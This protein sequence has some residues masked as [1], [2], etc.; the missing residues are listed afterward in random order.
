VTSA[1]GLITYST[2]PR[3]GVVHTLALAE[4]L[5]QQG[6]PVEVVALGDPA[7]GFFRRVDAP[8]HLIPAPPVRD[9]LEER[10]AAAVDALADG[11]REQRDGGTL[12]SIL[13]VQDCISARA[14]VRLRDEGTPVTVVRTVH[15][16]DD[17]TTPELVECQ[18]RSI[19]DPDRLVV[20]SR[21]WQ[22]RLAADYGVQATVVTNGVDRKRFSRVPSPGELATR[23]AQVGAENRF[24]V[25]TVGGIEPRK[26]S[27]HLVR[28][29]AVLRERLQPPAVLAVI[30]GYSFQDHRTYR[31]AVLS[32]LPDLGLEIGRDVVLLGTLPDD[33]MPGWYHA[34][35]AFAFPS[36]NEGFGLVVLEALAAGTPTVVADL[37]A[38]REYLDY[39]RDALVVAPGDDQALADQ[40]YRIATE[41]QLRAALAEAGREVAGRFT[42]AGCAREHL[43]LYASLSS[44][45]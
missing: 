4:A 39:G 8:H 34:A 3:G 1:V 19:L 5:H 26:G 30:G 11:L 21:I 44:I 45:G 16:V 27:D 22:D 10:V 36:V 43:A 38:F 23:R 32:S 33:E 15:H 40:L 12:P 37:P 29:M 6:A 41:P 42:W 24:L 20:V 25:L 35:D 2:K 7:E 14:A 28:A 9:T 18:L 31:E 13:H 17:F